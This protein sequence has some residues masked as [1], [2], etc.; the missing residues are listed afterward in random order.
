M[1]IQSIGKS[2]LLAFVGAGVIS[3]F[4][5][6]GIIPAL[7]LVQRLTGNVAQKSVVV[8]PTVYMRTCG[9][10][11]VIVSFLVLFLVALLR[12]HRREQNGAVQQ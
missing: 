5:M 2:L 4:L 12:F 1:R 6:M 3:F 11:L 7:A 8:N 10:P 9:I